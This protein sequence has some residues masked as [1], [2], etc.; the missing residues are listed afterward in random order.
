MNQ[1]ARNQIEILCYEIS[2]HVD[3]MKYERFFSF[4]KRCQCRYN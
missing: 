3:L 2:E 1:N 4:S